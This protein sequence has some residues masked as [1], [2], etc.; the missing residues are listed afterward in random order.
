MMTCAYLTLAE[1]MLDALNASGQKVLSQPKTLLG[2]LMDCMDP[3][4]DDLRVLE[5]TCDESLLK[6]FV[7]QVATEDPDVAL[8]AMQ[9]RAYLVDACVVDGRA[10]TFV[11]EGIAEGIARWKDV[12]FRPMEDAR[13]N[14]RAED[15]VPS[16]GGHAEIPNAPKA[17]DGESGHTVS[18]SLGTERVVPLDVAH[19]LPTR[20]RLPIRL[21]GVAALIVVGLV[22]VFVGRDIVAA[23]SH[24]DDSIQE[25]SDADAVAE[26]DSQEDED[27]IDDAGSASTD[28]VTVN[29]YD[30][31]GGELVQSEEVEPGSKV[32]IPLVEKDGSTL[33]R[34]DYDGN[35]LYGLHSGDEIVADR[36]LDVFAVWKSIVDVPDG[37]SVDLVTPNDSKT[38][39]NGPDGYFALEPRS[40]LLVHN[41]SKRDRK[42]SVEPGRPHELLG[43][44]VIGAGETG[45]FASEVHDSYEV[46]EWGADDP[47]AEPVVRGTY[48]ITIREVDVRKGALTIELG[49]LESLGKSWFE[50]GV[51]ATSD[52][53]VIFCDGSISYEGVGDVGTV[54]FDKGGSDIPWQDYDRRYFVEGQL[55]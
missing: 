23:L 52:G 54:Q 45:V 46:R 28:T 26:P 18:G 29:F 10:A 32:V 22:A 53:D 7:E 33:Q 30:G 36:D 24:V 6:P 20:R 17:R 40:V 25:T 55:V 37:I 49:N 4:S 43:Q 50:V 9:A 13:S 51:L 35:I 2:Y 38:V 27:A 5:R 3:D 8:A 19:P 39:R 16:I 31:E 1:A 47:D 48:D 42:L 15:D 44:F 34:W 14:V 21:V 12:P 41:K 11:A